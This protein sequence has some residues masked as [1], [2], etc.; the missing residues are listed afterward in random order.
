MPSPVPEIKDAQIV[1]QVTFD[2]FDAVKEIMNGNRV[3][4]IAWNDSTV[5]CMLIDVRLGIH[6]DNKDQDWI[7]TT[8][9]VEGKDWIVI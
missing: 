8:G 9:D 5:Y 4:R 7:I 6:I 2:F 1:E 3:T